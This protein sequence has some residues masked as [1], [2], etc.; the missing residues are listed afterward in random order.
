MMD[1]AA[2]MFTETYNC[3]EV[4]PLP[5]KKVETVCSSACRHPIP[6]ANICRGS[7]S[8]SEIRPP[9]VS[10]AYVQSDR[11]GLPYSYVYGLCRSRITL[12][13]LNEHNHTAE[14]FVVRDRRASKHGYID[15][16]GRTGVAVTFLTR[17]YAT[18]FIQQ[19]T[20]PGPGTQ[21]LRYRQQGDK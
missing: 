15:V 13:L 4:F 12:H 10:I 18:W 14:A 17:L 8:G 7:L 16:G 3:M 11:E 1:V 19:V 21:C 2:A 5:L 6:P 20:L 9:R